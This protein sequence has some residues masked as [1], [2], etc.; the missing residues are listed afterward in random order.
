VIPPTP[1]GSPP[2]GRG[3]RW[4]IRTKI[5]LACAIPLA[6]SVVAGSVLSGRASERQ[7]ISARTETASARAGAIALSVAL[8]LEMSNFAGLNS[9]VAAARADSDL[10]FAVVLDTLDVPIAAWPATA[11]ER[12]PWV[13]AMDQDAEPGAPLV[14]QADVRLGPLA[15]RHGRLLL[16]F[17]M[18]R[19]E[20][21]IREERILLLAVGGLLLLGGVSLVVI[22]A[23]RV[24]TPVRVLQQAT[25]RLAQEDFDVSVTVTTSD[26]VGA[27]AGDFMRMANRMREVLAQRDE[28]ARELVAARDAAFEAARA[29]SRFLAMMSHEI[30]TP[31]NGVIGMAGLLMQTPLDAEQLE[32]TRTMDR[33]ARA[34]L[35]ILNDVLDSAK[36][37]AGKLSFQPSSFRF[38]DVA[39]SVFDIVAPAAS[40]KGVDL[41]LNLDPA[42]PGHLV[43]DPARIRQVLLNLVGNAVSFTERGHVLV[44][45]TWNARAR[46]SPLLHVAVRDT[47]IGLTDAEQR[48]LFQ[49]F[50]QINNV[51]TRRRGGTGLGLSISR[52][53]VRL[54]GGEMGV[55]SRPGI[56]STFW[57]EL[58]L[59]P[60]V[61]QPL[62]AAELPLEN[63]D[64]MLVGD[65]G[66]VRHASTVALGAAGAA[67]RSVEDVFDAMIEL[68]AAVAFG[69]PIRV[70]IVDAPSEGTAGELARLVADSEDL[71]GTHVLRMHPFGTRFPPAEQGIAGIVFKP[72][73]PSHL[74]DVVLRTLASTGSSS[75]KSGAEA[76]DTAN[77]GS[78]DA[79]SRESTA[80]RRALLAE[81]NPVNQMVAARLLERL[82]FHVDVVRDGREA[83]ASCERNAYEVVFMDCQMPDMSGFEATS[84]LRAREGTL[85]RIPIIAMTADALVGDREACLAAGMDDYVSKPL[86]VDQLREAIDRV[87][88][89]AHVAA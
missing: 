29:K 6:V 88:G 75:F 83:I 35:G 48:M 72:V 69:T 20:R 7:S 30:R 13:G 84:V 55:E 26:E 45:V 40:A 82:G 81:D 38:E 58:P 49:P 32:Y 28:H 25:R 66:V 33:S 64:V 15:E 85:R 37:E 54:M 50:S 46:K 16:G 34:L 2:L 73:R 62:H 39:M 17:S 23:S 27:L 8:A 42:I 53:I 86:C 31:M 9:A 43:G 18:T 76:D 41:A 10:V 87:L 11:Y 21:Q 65:E 51:S 67:V 59:V 68:R 79:G 36:M 77:A 14:A 60:A 71:R 47:G 74:V 61:D 89:A 44:D 19:L 56:G 70:V 3:F 52:E 24:A 57:L 5:A 12:A 22:L 1:S 78:A 63:V 4:P 80:M